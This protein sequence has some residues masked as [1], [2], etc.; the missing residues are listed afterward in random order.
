MSSRRKF[1]QDTASLLV[2]IVA[3]DWFLYGSGRNLA[4]ASVAGDE[5]SQ[6]KIADVVLGQFDYADVTFSEHL[7]QEKQLDQALS[8]LLSLDDDSLLKPYRQRAGLP[9]PGKDLGGWYDE[10]AGYDWEHN[11]EHG[12]APGHCFG[13]WISALSRA[14]AIK[15][16][17]KYRDKALNLVRLYENTINASFYKDFRFPSYTYDK[18]VCGLIDA[19]E[20]AGDTRALEILERTT[21][22]ALPSLPRCALDHDEMRAL[23]HKNESYCWDESYT[24]PENL[25]LAYQR[26][27]GERYKDLAVRF[28]KD[29][30]YFNPLSENKNVLPDHHAYSY[31]N[32]LSSAMQA[33]LTL[34][35]D[36]HLRAAKNAFDMIHTTQSFA[37]G[38]WGPDESFKKPG[39]GELAKSLES[40]HNSFETPCG[41]YAHFKLTRYLLRVTHDTKYGDSMERVM[42]NTI[43]GAK[44]LQADGLGFYYSDY[45]LKGKKVYRT[46]STWTCCTGTLPQVAADYRINTYFHSPDALYINLY[47]PSK[48]CWRQ[49]SGKSAKES[50]PEK[51]IILS[52]SGNYPLDDTI[53]FKLAMSEPSEF[54]LYLRIP[55]WAEDARLQLKTSSNSGSADR[56]TNISDCRPGTFAR[57][58]R[59]WCNGDSL[60]LRLPMHFSLEPIDQEHSNLVALVRGPLVLF[61]LA[62]DSPRFTREQL[63]SAERAGNDLWRVKSDA[64]RYDFVPFTKITDEQYT[65]YV[66]LI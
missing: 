66:S 64:K 15:G 49:R 8:I 26:G 65:T 43:L 61:A 13:Q 25:F 58:H 55:A 12:F 3:A 18:L 28:L 5:Q 59:K 53:D 14:Y 38:A 21:D 35:S 1:L 7:L 31:M 51:A 47:I 39:A 23:P 16:E 54:S 48:V 57:L 32:A 41:S 52:Q 20:F 40:T 17:T 44:P 6:L 63:L 33:Y 22:A 10:F 56:W 46:T 19:H 60:R 24:L 36:K 50:T 34:G 45:N 27:A 37:T 9:A 4:R 2:S 29:D 11:V 42:Y 62:A 30:T